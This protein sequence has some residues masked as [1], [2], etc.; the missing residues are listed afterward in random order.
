VMGSDLIRPSSIVHR[1]S[2]IVH[3]PSSIVGELNTSFRSADE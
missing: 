2:S 3:R 1:P